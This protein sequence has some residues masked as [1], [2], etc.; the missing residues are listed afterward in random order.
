[1]LAR[2]QPIYEEL[3]GWQTS[4][5]EAERFED[6]PENAAR[7]V[8]RVEA[9]LGAPADIIGVG[10]ARSQTISRRSLWKYD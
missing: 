3:P 6:L 2:C 9:I 5:C 8:Q 4:I 1:M 7:F 10:P